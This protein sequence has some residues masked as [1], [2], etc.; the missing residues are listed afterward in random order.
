MKVSLEVRISI[1]DMLRSTDLEVRKVGWMLF[2]DEYEKEIIRRL[3]NEDF[4]LTTPWEARNF[5]NRSIA[6]SKARMNG[7]NKTNSRP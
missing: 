2:L 4:T 5:L 6:I 1:L 3:K 7:K